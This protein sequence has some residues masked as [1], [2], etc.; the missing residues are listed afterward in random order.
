[1]IHV[2]LLI[3]LSEE[4]GCSQWWAAADMTENRFICFTSSIFSENHEWFHLQS[5]RCRWRQMKKGKIKSGTLLSPINPDDSSVIRWGG[6]SGLFP[7]VD[8]CTG[9]WMVGNCLKLSLHPYLSNTVA[10]LSNGMQIVMFQVNWG[11]NS[12]SERETLIKRSRNFLY[13]GF[14]CSKLFKAQVI[15]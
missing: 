7:A 9:S 5:K 6:Q 8:Q 3:P 11:E 13:I 14:Y 1:M 15:G 10:S 4:G 12:E 2:F